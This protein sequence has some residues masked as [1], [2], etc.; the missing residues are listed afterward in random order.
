MVYEIA[1]TLSSAEAR[2]EDYRNKPE[3]F[4]IKF[5]TPINLD[6]SGGYYYMVALDKLK[7]QFSWK[8]ISSQLE[9][10]LFSYNSDGGSTFT[11]VTIP[12]GGY[13]YEG[14]NDFIKRRT[15]IKQSS[16]NDEYPIIISFDF[17]TLRVHVALKSGYQLDL[18][19][20]EIYELLGFDKVILKEEENVGV[21]L[22]NF[23]QHTES[24]QIHCDLVLDSIVNGKNTDI[25][26]ATST[27]NRKPGEIFTEEDLR[28]KLY[29][30]YQTK[31]QSV[32]MY[33]TDAIGRTVDLGGADVTFIIK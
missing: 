9:N 23:S 33:V 27:N 14:L 4:T 17:Y 13:S 22:P 2:L 16:S 6:T 31:I 8:N 24:L 5:S 12:D 10:Q 1:L 3:D 32:R 15:V 26:H 11:S 18:S 7:M 28:L 29:P 21:R 19:K 25:I 30:I 20:S